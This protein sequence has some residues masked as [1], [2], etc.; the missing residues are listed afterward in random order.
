[1]RPLAV[2]GNV[3][4]DLILGPAA[5]WPT[6]G[7]EIIVDHD[8]LRVGGAAGNA[9]LAWQ[10]LG[11]DFHIAANVGS[12]A[13][14]DWLRAGFGRRADAWPTE[15]E[16]TTLSVGITHPNGER[17]FFTTRGHLPMLSWPEVER[18]L[19]AATLDGGLLLLCGCFLH[20]RLAA[21]YDLLFDWAQARGITVAT[22]TGW[23]LYGWTAAAR[24]AA[25]RWLA[26]SPIALLNEVETTTL[27]D[28][29]DPARAAARLRALM[30][31]GAIFVVKR[32]PKGALAVDADGAVMSTPAPACKVV[33]TIGAGDVFNAGLLAALA[34]GS[35]LREALAAGVAT[36]S[37]AISTLPRRYDAV[38][39]DRMEMKA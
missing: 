23:P 9:A 6:P 24:A 16:G 15:I 3:N 27:G 21:D 1:M 20:D 26:R 10:G 4:V 13:F 7:T 34:A 37:A 31:A 32:G 12:D 33:D 29:A 5:P 36:A 17:T 35:P 8:E 39:L 22:D 18:M 19:G 28:D 25:R 2:V 14:G 30:P 38:P 11:H